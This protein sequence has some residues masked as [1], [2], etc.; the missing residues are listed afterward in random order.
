[1]HLKSINIDE[2]RIYDDSQSLA[3]KQRKSFIITLYKSSRILL[4]AITLILLLS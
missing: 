3:T 2:K 1:M 4:T